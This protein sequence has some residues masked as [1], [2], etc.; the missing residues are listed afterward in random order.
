MVEALSD[1]WFP[2]LFC[3]CGSV[4]LVPG[5][6]VKLELGSQIP[7]DLRL[8]DTQGLAVTEAALTGRQRTRELTTLSLTLSLVLCR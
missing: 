6:I 3:L 1:C 7:A 2:P 4:S 8:V 5:D